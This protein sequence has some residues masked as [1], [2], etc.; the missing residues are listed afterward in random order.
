MIVGLSMVASAIAG[1]A[2]V[3]HVSWVK[4]T[5]LAA[6][7]HLLIAFALVMYARSK[8]HRSMF[9][10]TGAELKKDRQWLK[11]LDKENRSTN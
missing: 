6:G 3:L 1:L 7:L 4:I 11:N 10:M 9:E 2:S 8:M 5:L